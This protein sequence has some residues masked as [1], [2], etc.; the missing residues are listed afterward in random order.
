MSLTIILLFYVPL[1]VVKSPKNNKNKTL[2]IEKHNKN[3]MKKVNFSNKTY[4]HS[5]VALVGW[6][7]VSRKATL[8]IS[9]KIIF[10]V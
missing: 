10:S 2:W 3:F 9:S 4:N 8:K 6:Q 7:L 1:A 5:R